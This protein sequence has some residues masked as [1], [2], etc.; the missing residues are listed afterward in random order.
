[1]YL[2]A[3]NIF[4][5]SY[6]RII[7]HVLYL[8]FLLDVVESFATKFNCLPRLM[9]D[10]HRRIENDGKPVEPY[11]LTT[12]VSKRIFVFSGKGGAFTIEKYNPIS[13]KWELVHS[14]NDNSFKNRERFGQI[15]AENKI[16]LIG[17][18]KGKTYMR[19]V[20]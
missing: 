12:A 13:D 17:G 18:K 8:Q 20:S 9:E 7:A 3:R 2:N 5:L 6:F 11:H 19:T 1:M 15:F 16:F 14:F 4:A 10:Y